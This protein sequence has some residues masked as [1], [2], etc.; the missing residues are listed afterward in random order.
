MKKI[1]DL[2]VEELLLFYRNWKWAD[3]VMNQYIKSNIPIGMSLLFE[4]S[5]G[6][7]FIWYGLVYVLIE[8][9][10]E[11]KLSIVNVSKNVSRVRD[12]LRHC[13]HATFHV[14]T[15][16]VSKKFTDIL[17]DVDSESDISKIHFEIKRCLEEEIKRRIEKTPAKY[18]VLSN[19]SKISP[20]E[21]SAWFLYQHPQYSAFWGSSI[22]EES[23]ES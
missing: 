2:N 22:A 20:L 3:M 12:L 7:K 18:K 10:E 21:D 1:S 4:P 19:I 15:K 13:R 16:I 5:N 11:K 17:M 23:V 14:P 9:I 6:F 8:F